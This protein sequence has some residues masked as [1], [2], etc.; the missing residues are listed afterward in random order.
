MIEAVPIWHFE[1]L[2]FKLCFLKQSNT[3]QRV[4]RFLLC[5]L[6]VIIILF[7]EGNKH[8]SIVLPLVLKMLLSG[9]AQARVVGKTL[10]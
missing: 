10:D 5:L 7:L 4:A 1:G 2:T 9:E 8:W 3:F 6:T